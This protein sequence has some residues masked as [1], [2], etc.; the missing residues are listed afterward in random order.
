MRLVWYMFIVLLL[1]SVLVLALPSRVHANTLLV[2]SSYSTIQA[3]ILAANPAGGDTIQVSPG[4]YL[5]RLTIIKPLHIVGASRD[6]TFIDGQGLGTV[7]WV[8]S[9]GVEVKG[10]TIRNSDQYGWGIHVENTQGVNITGN[11]I[12]AS[13]QGDGVN[14][15][16]ANNTIVS[17]NIFTMNLYAVNVTSSQMVRILNNQAVLENNIGVQL[18]DSKRN[19]VLNNTFSGGE[20]GLDVFQSSGNNITRNL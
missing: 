1:A 13:S 6:S 9:T 8:N 19:L 11:T 2:P 16:K 10:F 7:V 12:S 5:E 3:A 15:Y 4:T 20:D 18:R 17:N 14:L